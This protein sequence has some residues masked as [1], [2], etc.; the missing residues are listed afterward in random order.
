MRPWS[1]RVRPGLA[2][3]GA[4]PPITARSGAAPRRWRR[5]RLALAGA[6]LVWQGGCA[7]P[8]DIA[9]TRTWMA[10]PA[11]SASVAVSAVD[12]GWPG[13][14][15]WRAH[16]DAA[17]DDL[18]E[19]ALAS[20]PSLKIAQARW[21]QASAALDSVAAAQSPQLTASADLTDQRFTQNGMVPPPLAGSVRWNNNLQLGGSWDL[22]LWGRQRAALA[23][24]I[25]Q[26]RA[27]QADLQAAHVLLAAQVASG[28][29]QLARLLDLQRLAAEAVRQREQIVALV[30]QRIG[31]G[32]DTTL[33]LRQAE[34]LL[35]Q[36]RVEQ[37]ANDEAASRARHALAELAGAPPESLRALSPSLAG[38]HAP[39]LREAVPADLLGRRAD[40]V[41]Q[42]W[43]VE[44]ALGEVAAARAQFY[45]NV[46]LVAFVGLSSLGL[47]SLLR[48][49]SA[50]AG[51][52]PA[53]RLPI[54]DGGRL[55]AN[56]QGRS[57]EVDAAIEAYDATLLRALR[58]VADALAS[59]PSLRRQ[60]ALQRRASEAAEAAADLAGQRYRA[61]LGNFLVV[62][63]AQTNLLV[64]Q[65]A[66]ADLRARQLANQVMLAQALGG[67]WRLQGEVPGMPG[68]ALAASPSL[69]VVR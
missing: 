4:Q 9:P 5:S 38:L 55:R 53:L 59:E 20:Q 43:R 24:A 28:Y 37:Q 32:L 30:R 42:R 11:A 57:A 14:R 65:R 56:L 19:R 39:A 10:A 54:F 62:L 27:V 13:E 45:P 7:A 22:D 64:Q 46:N 18:V 8:A 44:A 31:A 41:A 6:L 36:A 17:L 12:T 26:Q 66:A 67:G 49:G 35:A 48:A 47:D 29:V 25:G 61:G 1:E 63:T 34:G 2:H 68:P 60:Q 52:G 15:W 50:T 16:G 23:S 3:P 40:L 21:R 33:D 69:P 51:V 58:E